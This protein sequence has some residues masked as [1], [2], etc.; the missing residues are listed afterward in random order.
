MPQAS[1]TTVGL[2][3][4][5]QVSADIAWVV[6]EG[7]LILRT[8]NGGTTWFRQTS[9]TSET[10]R[11]ISTLNANSAFALAANKMLLRT[12]N[13]GTNWESLPIIPNAPGIWLTNLAAT[14]QNTVIIVGSGGTILRT[15]DSGISW[16]RLPSG[17]GDEL[18]GVSFIDSNIGTVVGY[19]GTVLR[20]E[21]GGT[22]WIKEEPLKV[23]PTEAA[24]YQNYP[25]PFNPTTTVK[26]QLS[27]TGFVTLRVYDL[28]GSEV[29]TLVGEKMVPGV[30]ERIFHGDNLASGV[31]LCR[32]QV[33]NLTATKKLL[34]LR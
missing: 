6:G 14:D 33:G 3:D 24:L 15:T 25:N 32:L 9:G 34:L 18:Y 11:A 16:V 10:I 8:T 29:A 7:G 12:T 23:A 4:V 27:T 13:G 30:Y 31:Y 26:F 28:Q 5:S 17:T 21:N 20:T 2:W 1:G 19:Y 22:T